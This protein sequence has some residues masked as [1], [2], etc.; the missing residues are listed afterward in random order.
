MKHIKKFENKR[1]NRDYY[2]LLP[3]DDRFED[4][5]K[6]INCP[7]PRIYEFLRNNNIENKYIFI[8]NAPNGISTSSPYWAWNNYIDVEYDITFDGMGF[9]YMGKINILDSEFVAMK[10]NI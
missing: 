7:T 2:W 6:Q 10:Y 8:A 3:T 5:L 9:K 1:S 4:S